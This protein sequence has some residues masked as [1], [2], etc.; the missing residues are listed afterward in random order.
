MII[1]TL[2]VS[3]MAR[4]NHWSATSRRSVLAS[5]SHARK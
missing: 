5:Q 1:R 3:L 4:R 2:I